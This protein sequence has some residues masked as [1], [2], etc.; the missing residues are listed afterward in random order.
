[1]NGFG[2]R[3]LQS[4]L[5]ARRGSKATALAASVW[6]DIGHHILLVDDVGEWIEVEGFI[7]D[8]GGVG[9]V[10]EQRSLLWTSHRHRDV[11]WG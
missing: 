10:G 5:L 7:R 6:A 3:G 11:E 8:R 9:M 1:M 4:L 2:S